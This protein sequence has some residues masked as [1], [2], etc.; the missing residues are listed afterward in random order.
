LGIKIDLKGKKFSK[1][2]VLENAG[3]DKR[4]ESLW[5]C[6]CDCGKCITTKYE[7]KEEITIGSMSSGGKFLIDTNMLLLVEGYN[8]HLSRAGYVVRNV[9]DI[10]GDKA[11]FMHREIIKAPAR[12]VVDHINRE[13]YDNR[14][15]NLRVCTQQQNMVNVGM[16]KTITSGYKGV[17]KVEN[18]R[19][20]AYIDYMN[21]RYHLGTYDTASEAA[22]QRDVVFERLNGEYAWLNNSQVS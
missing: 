2:S 11:I 14:L 7:I 15:L 1:L 18:G 12:L 8:W 20:R 4:G 17:S 3:C 9:R 21:K 10:N 6:V 19:F 5:R 13:K 22:I 16:I